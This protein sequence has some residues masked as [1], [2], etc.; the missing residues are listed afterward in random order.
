EAVIKYRL[1]FKPAQALLEHDYSS[2]S[3]WH[4]C[5]KDAGILGQNAHRYNGLGFGN[6]SERI[7]QGAF[8]ISGTQTGVLDE[9]TAE[10]YAL[11]SATDIAQNLV[12]AQGRIEPSSE[13]LSHAAVYA[14]DEQIKFVFH[15]HSPQ[16][17]RARSRLGLPQTDAAISYGTPQMANEIKY[18]YRQGLFADKKVLAMAGHEDGIIGF[19]VTASEAGES[20]MQMLN[21]C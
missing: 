5:F 8:L 3:K 12:E 20:I 2:L 14:L 7:D 13:S 19:G 1:V 18:L 15:V 4:R 11:V 21:S 17:W 10:N 9:L 16:I 6:L